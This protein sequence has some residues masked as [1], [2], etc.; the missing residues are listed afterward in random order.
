M[1]TRGSGWVKEAHRYLLR[2]PDPQLLHTTLRLRWISAA[3]GVPIF[4][5][6]CLLFG[7]TGSLYAFGIAMLAYLLVN[8][9]LSRALRRSRSLQLWGC[10][11]V[12]GDLAALTVTLTIFDQLQGPLVGM[13]AMVLLGS[14]TMWSGLATVIAGMVGVG[15]YAT[16]LG[17]KL[18]GVLPAGAGLERLQSLDAFGFATLVPLALLVLFTG[19]TVILNYRLLRD[20]AAS[21]EDRYRALFNAMP[22]PILVV[23][24]ETGRYLECNEASRQFTGLSRDQFIGRMVGNPLEPEDR[25][26]LEALVRQAANAPTRTLLRRWAMKSGR[27]FFS[28]MALTPVEFKGRE[29]VLMAGRDCT[30]EVRLDEERREYAAK[31]QREVAQRTQDL[32]RTNT[33]L[34]QL[35]TRLVEAERLGIAGEVAGGIAHAIYNPLAALIGHMEMKLDSDKVDPRDE[36]VMHLARR[37]EAVVEGMLT[38]SRRGAMRPEPMDLGDLVRDVRRELAERCLT[39]GVEVELRIAPNLPQLTADHALL[40]TALVSVAENAL[41]AMENGGKL[42]LAV[43]SV[44]ETDALRLR[45][46]DS[47]PGVPAKIRGR[48]FEPFYSTKL[49]GVGL[50]LAIARG[51][52]LG[53]EGSIRLESEPGSGTEVTLEIPQQGVREARR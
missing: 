32:E 41:D 42:V 40:T 4:G 12:V 45:V 5:G 49:R 10:L 39:Q 6:V 22:T 37:I 15:C 33:K 3:L 52:I 31:L 16:A 48:I 7:S 20:R 53:H 43:E 50:G 1:G 27:E 8:A 44:S 34:R 51:I 24:R 18:G 38:L 28:E 25:A 2:G 35:Q 17:L 11:S 36:H 19:Y 30:A 9:G 29:A 26:D 23:D 47:G 21:V 14:A 46:R 13:Y